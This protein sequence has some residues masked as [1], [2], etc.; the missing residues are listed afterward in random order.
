MNIER[1]ISKFVVPS[2]VPVS[3]ALSQISKNKRGFVLCVAP[4]G[5][6]D[7]VLTDGD[8]RRWISAASEINIEEPVLTVCNRSPV[9]APEGAPIATLA[10]MFDSRITFVPLVAADGRVTSVALAHAVDGFEI[11]GRMIG[12]KQPAFIIAEIGI[13]HNGSVELA[14][15]LI[16][17]SIEAGS[18]LAVSQR[19]EIGRRE[20]RSRRAIHA[21][22][23][24]TSEFHTRA[25]ERSA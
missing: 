2:D 4:S 3:A 11:A 12:A 20:R 10:E 7:G 18:F 16:E 19:V 1:N 15:E 6:L 21:R 25:N 13:N 24:G 8:F 5:R 23:A 22:R 17:R 14:K 9:T